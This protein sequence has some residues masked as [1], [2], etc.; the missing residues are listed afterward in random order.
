MLHNGLGRAFIFL[1][2]ATAGEAGANALT[3]AP[4]TNIARI[5]L[6]SIEKNAPQ[7]D[8]TRPKETVIP[9]VEQGPAIDGKLDDECWKQASRAANFLNLERFKKTVPDQTSV[10]LLRD[11]NNLYFG[12]TCL[13]TNPS[14]IRAIAGA[15][16]RDTEQILK[17][18]A[19]EIMLDTTLSRNDSYRWVVNSKGAVWDCESHRLPET[20]TMVHSSQ[21]DSRAE[22]AGRPEGKAWI[23]EIKIPLAC[24][25]PRDLKALRENKA[26][27]LQLGRRNPG[28]PEGEL[29]AWSYSFD[30]PE[31]KYFGLA[32][33]SGAPAREESI[34]WEQKT[35][36]TLYA[37]E[38]PKRFG[39]A[40][41]R[42]FK[43][44]ARGPDD[45]AARNPAENIF[46]PPG[47]A[48][49]S[50]AKAVGSPDGICLVYPDTAYAKAR[51]YGFLE[52]GALSGSPAGRQ[53]YTP[54]KTSLGCGYLWS[55]NPAEFLF[56]LPAG[57]YAAVFACGTPDNW[58][59]VDME[60]EVNGVK[61]PLRNLIPFRVW[62]PRWVEFTADN[63]RPVSVK[64]SG[65]TK[66]ALNLA[67]VGPAADLPEATRAYCWIERDFYNYPVEHVVLGKAKA[68][69]QYPPQKGVSWTGEEQEAGFA[70]VNLP[71]T[72]YTP[73]NYEPRYEDARGPL[74]IITSAGRRTMAQ[75]AVCARRDLKRLQIRMD[76]P[77]GAE[78]AIQLMRTRYSWGNMGRGNLGQ[79]GFKAVGI[80]RAE[81]VWLEQGRCQP[82]WFLVDTASNCA[83]GVYRGTAAVYD[84]DAKLAEREL[85]ITVLPFSPRNRRQINSIYFNPPLM[86]YSQHF[87]D[88][89]TA[90]EK[91]LVALE[92][93]LQVRD[94]LNHGIDKVHLMGTMKSLKKENDGKWHYRPCEEEKLTLQIMKDAG[95]QEY[96]HFLAGYDAGGQI[97]NEEASR[98][99][100][101][102]I[103]RLQDRY[104]CRDKLSTAFFENL[105]SII[106]EHIESRRGMGLPAPAY[107]LW[108]EPGDI[109]APALAPFLDA[110]HRGGGRTKQ[111]LVA[112]CFPALSGRVDVK[113]YNGIALGVD[114]GEA[115]S[116][117]EILRR[118]QKEHAEYLVY[119]NS[120]IMVCDP[121]IARQG[122]GY[123][124]W[125]WNLDGLDPYKYW[126]I[127]GDPLSAASFHPLM[128]DESGLLATTPSWEAHAD[129]I[130]D[131]CLLQELEDIV[132]S[133]PSAKTTNAASFLDSLKTACAMPISQ[134][135]WTD[136]PLTGEVLVD[137]KYRWPACRYEFLRA[138]LAG[139]I[140][141][142]RG[143][144]IRYP[145]I[146]AEISLVE[147]EAGRQEEIFWRRRQAGMSPSREGNL[148]ANGSF[149]LGQDEKGVPEG[150]THWS[151]R[152]AVQ[153]GVAHSGKRSL[154]FK[155][156]GV[157]NDGVRPAPVA[158]TAG[159]TY[160]FSA[161]AM[162]AAE[163][164]EVELATG[165]LLHT[166]PAEPGRP[167][168]RRE[169]IY[170]PR[171][172][173]SFDWKK[174]EFVFTAEE[175]ERFACPWVYVSDR[176]GVFYV[177]DMELVELQ[178]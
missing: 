126:K 99:G 13:C 57:R 124:A 36:G 125:G 70:L 41:T 81:P 175:N 87:W 166:Q 163:T 101:K 60:I 92:T 21:W 111:T 161:W 149:E 44:T 165:F 84:G 12:F 77:P 82:Y 173:P 16:E 24:F 25:A 167:Y 20:D 100:I 108:D 85:R 11:R 98:A 3:N 40:F 15:G 19:I 56:D 150:F 97:L 47:E 91:D 130:Y 39:Y 52:T 32:R 148:I 142:L 62:M 177:D 55:D 71:A 88:K 106:R 141:E 115:A 114:G 9:L 154:C 156:G 95:L 8:L 4:G 42:V 146:A 178:D 143:L 127:A 104:Q 76:N 103:E 23:A 133:D 75:L 94:L 50:G 65:A 38:P 59:P 22:V 172:V 7:P 34:A 157:A 31:P 53:G 90:R 89:A 74:R 123:W 122:Y 137:K 6:G 61:A 105:S 151:A 2:L 152:A 1:A 79:M 96:G 26:W 120:T 153:A 129:G 45:I 58:A 128:F 29:S 72:H 30:I 131:N 135:G 145:E 162:R 27:G 121:R 144:S 168:I 43:F 155:P 35:D 116:P 10:L 119:Y 159:K 68:W 83:P 132:M 102:P 140:M 110:I 67:A 112:G 51:G 93:R 158:L 63:S 33:F 136:S 64:L 5:E 113:T 147:K 54:G 28:A 80:W 171:S 37:T 107:E 78:F 17:D 134:T 73:D 14:N 164:G 169:A 174:F 48:G 117:A 176:G 138:R 160:R 46:D 86:A 170:F 66:W 109:G 69:V 118:R 49:A 18:D 139:M